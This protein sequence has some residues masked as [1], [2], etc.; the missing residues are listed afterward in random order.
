MNVKDNP[1][2]VRKIKLSVRV[3][4]EE[5]KTV[6]KR[7]L[8]FGY[9]SKS[10]Y[11]REVALAG[12]VVARPTQRKLVALRE[13]VTLLVCCKSLLKK[14]SNPNCSDYNGLIKKQLEEVDKFIKE[15]GCQ[16]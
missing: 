10:D 6:I 9:N 3:N 2:E 1:E 5:S 8:E 12:F 15:Y 16:D 7:S 4:E 13:S 11:V 14:L